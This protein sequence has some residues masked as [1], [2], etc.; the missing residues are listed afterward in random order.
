MKPT[1]FR[2]AAAFRAWL[3]VNHKTAK[4][5]TLQLVK[6]HAADRGMTYPEALDEALCYG[7]IDGVRR[8]HD[9]DSY[10]QRFSPR[11]PGSVWSKINIGHVRRLIKT[12]RMTK[13]G[14]TEFEKRDR[15]VGYDRDAPSLRPGE[16]R[17]FRRDAPA[18]A[19]FSAARPSYRRACLLWVADAKRDETRLRRLDTLIA[20]SAKGEP[21][22]PMRGFV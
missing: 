15:V 16:E 19:Y 22:P 1:F 13:A 5:I 6:N 10:A 4:E 14:L 11:R 9:A 2:D 21:I 8:R 18:W 20:S 7:W 17:R 12:R 3:R